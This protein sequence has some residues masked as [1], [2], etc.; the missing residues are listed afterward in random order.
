MLNGLPAAGTTKVS[1]TPK[2]TYV[3][4]PA[5][6][7]LAENATGVLIVHNPLFD[8][9]V[10]RCS[11]PVVPNPNHPTNANQQLANPVDP[12]GRPQRRRG[13][14]RRQRV[15][16]LL[17]W[18]LPGAVGSWFDRRGCPRMFALGQV[19]VRARPAS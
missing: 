12:A 1:L 13:Q 2:V 10:W 5:D 4:T 8:A 18:G 11:V 6:Y 7:D 19:S 3:N 14:R 16:R 17:E 9:R 15:E